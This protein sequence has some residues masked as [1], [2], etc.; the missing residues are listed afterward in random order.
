VALIL[1][2][3]SLR[4]SS[5][6]VRVYGGATMLGVLTDPPT[7][8]DLRVALMTGGAGHLSAVKIYMYGTA[9]HDITPAA[10]ASHPRL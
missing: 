10:S 6:H 7:V 9:D 1:P 8:A 4:R 5:L 3:G 2:E